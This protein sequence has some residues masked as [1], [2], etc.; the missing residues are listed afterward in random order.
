M[1]ALASSSM[2]DCIT[3]AMALLPGARSGPVGTPSGMKVV[4]SLK[5]GTK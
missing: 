5:F 3:Q 2:K 4:S 1:A